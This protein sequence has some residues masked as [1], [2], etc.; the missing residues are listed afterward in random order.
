LIIPVKYNYIGFKPIKMEDLNNKTPRIEELT[1]TGYEVEI[2]ACI[3]EAFEIFKKYPGGFIGFVLLSFGISAVLGMIPVVGSIVSLV[4]S[5]AIN[6]GAVIVAKKIRYGEAYEFNDFF[7]GFQKFGELFLG[8]LLM[9]VMIIIGF[10]FLVLPG[11]YL[12][13]AY[14]F[15][16]MLI[17]FTFDGQ[18]WSTLERSRRLISREWFSFF[19]F[20]IVI[21]LLNLAGAL[22]LLVG[23]LVTVPVSVIAL[24]VCFD[25]LVGTGE[26]Q[27]FEPMD[28]LTGTI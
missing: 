25:K 23:L 11:I 8:S 27:G 17:W 12:A 19:A 20:F 2:S 16:Q 5:P 22:C 28:H 4:I 26:A 18:Y 21:L 13:V 24:F 14:C 7:K 3:S 9:Y 10:I 6:I 15:V 1:R